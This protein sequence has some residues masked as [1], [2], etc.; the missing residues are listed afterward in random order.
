MIDCES[1]WWRRLR[2]PAAKAAR[3]ASSIIADDGEADADA[4]GADDDDD[5]DDDDDGEVGDEAVYPECEDEKHWKPD[6]HCVQQ[7]QRLLHLDRFIQQKLFH[8]IQ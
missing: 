5:D 1:E 8:F 4:A 3:Q 7:A 6:D 2:P